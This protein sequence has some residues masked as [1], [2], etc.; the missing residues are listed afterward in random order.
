[1]TT[2]ESFILQFVI[3]S[4]NMKLSYNIKPYTLLKGACS[5]IIKITLA[6]S[7][8]AIELKILILI[9]Q[10]IHNQ[11]LPQNSANLDDNPDDSVSLIFVF[12]LRVC[13]WSIIFLLPGKITVS[14]C[15]LFPSSGTCF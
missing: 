7:H 12:C 9:I 4:Y 6:P 2:I 15:L 10:N 5:E 11:I 1:M 14:F 8:D 13:V 3:I